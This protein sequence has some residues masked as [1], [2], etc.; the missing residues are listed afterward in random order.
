M[1]NHKEITDRRSG[2]LSCLQCWIATRKLHDQPRHNPD[3]NGRSPSSCTSELPEM[4][5]RLV[6]TE[7]WG[8]T[9][10]VRSWCCSSR[11]D[12]FRFHWM[13]LPLGR[14]SVC[15]S[16]W[17]SDDI[18][19]WC[20]C[21]LEDKR[22][23]FGLGHRFLGIGLADPRTPSLI[24]RWSSLPFGSSWNEINRKVKST[25]RQF[26]HELVLLR[27]CKFTN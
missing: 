15:C 27:A 14:R 13:F 7:R 5:V 1:T 6:D 23:V 25:K 26:L 24:W 21:S 10:F 2:S 19:C 18:R 4:S 12:H 20:F 3:E 9:C 17:M 22:T 8:R 16:G 11:R